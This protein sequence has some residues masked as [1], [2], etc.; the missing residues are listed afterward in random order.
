MRR[1]VYEYKEGK[2]RFIVNDDDSVEEHSVEENDIVSTI[3]PDCMKIE[4]VCK[5]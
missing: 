1:Q 5:R 3:C 2:K 4:C